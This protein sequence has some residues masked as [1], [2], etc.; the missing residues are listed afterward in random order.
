MLG[1]TVISWVL[2]IPAVLCWPVVFFF[3]WLVWRWS[4]RHEEEAEAQREA[5]L[6]AARR[7]EPE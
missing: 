6:E 7:A 4:K 2:L 1:L 3:G 5:L